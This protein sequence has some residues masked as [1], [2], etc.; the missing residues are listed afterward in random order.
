M[1]VLAFAFTAVIVMALG[2]VVPLQ[3][4]RR[5]GVV[6]LRLGGLLGVMLALKGLAYLQRQERPRH[7]VYL[8]DQSASI[9]ANQRKWVARRLASLEAIR[10]RQVSRSVLAFGEQAHMVFPAGRT[11]L[12]DAGPIAQALA[13]SPI[14]RNNTNLEAALL[15]SF[16]TMPSQD[17]GRIILL[18]DGRQ[19]A[20]D[21]ERIFPHL[22]RL[23]LE[24]FPV[25]VPSTEPA[26]LIWEQLAVPPLVQRGAFVPIKLAFTNPTGR[27][28]PLE[29]AVSL[30]GL[31]LTRRQLRVPPGWRVISTSVPA[32]KTGTM[33]LEVS[34]ASP[35]M[36]TQQ[37]MAY[38][39]VE[40]PPQLLLVLER[41]TE[42]PLFATALKRR[43]MEIAVLTPGE[44]PIEVGKL[45]DYDAVLLFHVP[46]SALNEAQVEAL[47]GYVARFG[48]GIV[49]VGMG[50]KLDEETTRTAPLD[51][52]LPVE[53]EPK[54][55]REAKRRV[56]VL[57][58]IDR[59]ASMM[60][61]RIAATKRGAV[62][63]V[64]QL[65][66]EDLVGVLAFDTM[67]YVIVDVQPAGQ[68]RSVLIEK[69]TRLKSTGGTDLLP[70]LKAAQA[71][72]ELTGTTVK[73]IILLSDGN[74]PFDSQAY[75]RMLAA[76]TKAS[77]TL[78]TIG[79]GSAFVNTELLEWLATRTGGTFYQMTNLDELP[80]LIAQ[81]T[82][83]ALGRIAF[84]EG[85]FRPV[86]TQ[87]SEW[88]S[89]LPATM[90]DG[91]AGIP[92]WPP[93]RGYLT[94][95]AK[96]GARLELGIH[97]APHQLPGSRTAVGPL[98]R[99]FEHATAESDD[100][101]IGAGQ[102]ESEDPLL[103]HWEVGT[104]R[105]VVFTSD[106]DTRWSP[107]WIRWPQ[108]EGVWASVLRWTMRRQKLQELFVWLDEQRA[109]AHV[110][111]EGELVD[112]TAELV[113]SEG[114]TFPLALVTLS[115]FRWRASLE[116]VDSGWYQVVVQSHSDAGPIL[117]KRWIQLGRHEESAELGNL[118]PDETLLRR[119]AQATQGVVDEPDRA[120]LPPTAWVR[121]SVPLRWWLL[122]LVALLLLADVALRGRTM[123]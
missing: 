110:V 94:S 105:V 106:A 27:A 45:L 66:P 67:P 104:G 117:A 115:P 42:L 58:L 90:S 97:Q 57:L 119:I 116:H 98:D 40:G 32:L 59:S 17:T 74:T 44:L 49:M 55:V 10:P 46:K 95:T 81:D 85:Y 101:Q 88:F 38:V 53:F 18:S 11:P 86:R 62:E 23:G 65:A 29:V 36:P 123:L 91:Q 63:L 41:P 48:G 89:D 103:A 114:R 93:L 52:L 12:T 75:R 34:V 3:G 121:E 64:K 68:V 8:V 76:L 30:Q 61:P 71:R 2:R 54:G 78:S 87:G 113:S 82:Q 80:K 107:D 109:T 1:D 6:C 79:I 56:C 13:A 50:G 51:R 69:L 28:Q 25:A 16:S 24:V 118:P 20:G 43:D 77:I 37:R 102:V 7:L 120:F 15:A 5:I 73:H 92:D 14:N 31:T 21:V 35:K 19:T 26:G 72:L 22:R 111:I 122:P 70:A 84:T 112:P 39:E 96:P 108:F 47:E 100:Q 4:T 60:G 83:N 33:V 99:R 9:D